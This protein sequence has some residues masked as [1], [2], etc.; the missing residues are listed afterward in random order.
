M[1]P[2]FRDPTIFAL[3]KFQRQIYRQRQ[4][5]P[6]CRDR[7]RFASEG[8]RRYLLIPGWALVLQ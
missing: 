1:F 2:A 5:A 3:G 6:R 8:W 7:F 4:V